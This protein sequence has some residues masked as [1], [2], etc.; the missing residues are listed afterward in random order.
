MLSAYCVPGTGSTATKTALWP[1]SPPQPAKDSWPP[2]K[3]MNRTVMEK[4]Q[5]GVGTAFLEGE[6]EKDLEGERAG[7]MPGARFPTAPSPSFLYT[8]GHGRFLG[9]RP[10]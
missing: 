8:E 1:W 7:S 10:C 3:Q 9:T 6:L 4:N 2:N 5:G